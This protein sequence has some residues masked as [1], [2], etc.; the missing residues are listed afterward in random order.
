MAHK[1]KK[2]PTTNGRIL[3]ASLIIGTEDKD[4]DWSYNNETR[5]GVL[6][7][8]L[9]KL[10]EIGRIPDLLVCPGGYF[11]ADENNPEAKESEILNEIPNILLRLA[12]KTTVIAGFDTSSGGLDLESVIAVNSGGILKQVFKIFPAPYKADWGSKSYERLD[13]SY[14]KPNLEDRIIRVKGKRILLTC[15]HD[16]FGVAGPSPQLK[17]NLQSL[18]T[19]RKPS[20]T[21][22]EVVANQPDQKKWRLRP[23]E[24]V[25]NCVHTFDG[26][27]RYFTSKGWAKVCE[28]TGLSVVSAVFYEKTKCPSVSFFWKPDPRAKSKASGQ[29]YN[30]FDWF[31]DG[32]DEEYDWVW[33]QYFNIK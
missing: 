20:F 10:D 27:P 19:E 29:D 28:R 1:K 22:E 3:A 15:C 33:C 18:I 31:I 13:L 2:E 12:K 30:D 11:I 17:K 14:A 24:L 32:D 7:R 4:N 5:L 25:I 23:P 8:T 26:G 6:I 16:I 9:L 21:I